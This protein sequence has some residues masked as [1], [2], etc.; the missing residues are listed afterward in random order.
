MWPSIRG[1]MLIYATLNSSE[2]NR[3]DFIEY[4]SDHS[5]ASS[6]RHAVVKETRQVCQS[7]KCNRNHVDFNLKA[8]WPTAQDPVEADPS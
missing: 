8:R 3:L 6:I 7:V 5:R 4:L 2:C 1:D